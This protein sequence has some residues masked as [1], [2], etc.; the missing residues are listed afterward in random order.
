MDQEIC[1]LVAAD[2][3]AVDG[4]VRQDTTLDLHFDGVTEEFAPMDVACGSSV[5]ECSEGLLNFALGT[6]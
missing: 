6:K 4:F 1:Y 2:A 5:M 3:F